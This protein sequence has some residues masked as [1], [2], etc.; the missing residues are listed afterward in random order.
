[1]MYHKAKTFNDTEAMAAILKESRPR[2]QKA[3]GRKVEGFTDEKWD[4]VKFDTV[5]QANHLKF[6]S[7]R[8]GPTDNS[9]HPS[10]KRADH[11]ESISLRHLLLSTGDREL[12][13]ASGFDRVWG[14]GY[15][16]EEARGARQSWGQNLLG[17]ALMEVRRRLKEAAKI[18]DE[19]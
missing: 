11:G 16:A 19:G 17:K 18:E 8:A 3:L 13:E 2:K 1:M 5:V 10:E 7:S 4:R 9:A 6:G 15:K 14:I 12:A